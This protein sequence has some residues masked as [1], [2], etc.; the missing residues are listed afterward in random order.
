MAKDEEIK[1]MAEKW[2]L[3]L[4]K[5]KNGHWEFWDGKE[6]V[7]TTSGTP[8]D[9][10][11]FKNCES[12]LRR[13]MEK[14]LGEISYDELMDEL[15]KGKVITRYA[16]STGAKVYYL[17]PN[18][19]ERHRLRTS[20]VEALI[21]DELLETAGDAPRKVF[22]RLK[23]EPRAVAEPDPVVA[24]I[25]PVTDASA[26]VVRDEGWKTALVSLLEEIS[27]EERNIIL[28]MVKDEI[29]KIKLQR[30]KV[31]L[32]GELAHILEVH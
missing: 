8:G 32:E 20:L 12:Q 22:L 14:R 6:R 2:G 30:E 1:A 10:R 26:P 21:K 27:E 3:S 18:T 28:L 24:V 19:G 23:K 31:R 29:L 7:L 9:R 5:N 17:G 4:Q 25:V 15:K 11:G 13:I 16:H